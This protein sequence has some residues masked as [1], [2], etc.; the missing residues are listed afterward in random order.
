MSDVNR[1][2]AHCVGQPSPPFLSLGLDPSAWNEQLP[3]IAHV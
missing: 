1:R 3:V 2:G